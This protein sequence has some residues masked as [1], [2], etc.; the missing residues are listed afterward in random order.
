MTPSVEKVLQK[1]VN[2]IVDYAKEH[3]GFCDG[4]DFWM[5]S[6]EFW[7]KHTDDFERA[8]TADYDIWFEGTLTSEQDRMLGATA[9]V[10]WDGNK[11]IFD[12][13]ED[14]CKH[15][16][17]YIKD[18]DGS[19]RIYEYDPVYILA[20][21]ISQKYNRLTSDVE[22][23]QDGDEIELDDLRLKYKKELSYE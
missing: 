15:T 5:I 21:F 7:Q 11:I 13:T 2:A 23:L 9:I 6:D 16:I 1:Y 22:E 10:K 8:I 20:N 18:D 19:Y 14:D 17:S 4:E 12:I 3:D